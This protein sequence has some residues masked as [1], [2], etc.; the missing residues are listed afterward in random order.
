MRMAPDKTS[1]AAG[2]SDEAVTRATGKTW[3]QWFAVLDKAGARKMNHKS[4]A[5]YLNDH[6][7]FG[8]WWC[9]M[10]AVGYE[11]GTGLRQKHEKPGGFEISRSK[12]VD[13]PVAVLFKAWVS[14]AFRRQWFAEGPVK[15]RTTSTNKSL[16][17]TW[18]DG[19]QVISVNF[20]EKGRTK[21]HVAVQH[22]K[23]PDAQAAEKMKAYW[24]KALQ[25]LKAHL[26][27]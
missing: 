26:E 17:M 7:D 27:S 4:I 2:I 8:S 11:Q 24:G 23:L 16:R 15:I 1:K 21:S 20:S 6:Y 10:V 19:A 18:M 9:Q 14:P 22:G 25:R 12:V 5:Q 3:K 13:V